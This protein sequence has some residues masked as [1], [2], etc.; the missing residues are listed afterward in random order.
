MHIMEFCS[1]IKKTDIIKFA[2]KWV[3]QENMQSEVT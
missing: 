3:E 2:S 1:T